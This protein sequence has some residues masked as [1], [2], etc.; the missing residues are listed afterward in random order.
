MVI[1]IFHD[2]NKALIQEL[3]M[4]KDKVEILEKEMK[5]SQEGDRGTPGPQNLLRRG[6][7]ICAHLGRLRV[8]GSHYRFHILASLIITAVV[9]VIYSNTLDAAFHLD[10]FKQ[11]IDTIRTL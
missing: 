4:L 2:K 3:A 6:K 5:T 8:T 11:I 9:A 10:D 7:G 1:S